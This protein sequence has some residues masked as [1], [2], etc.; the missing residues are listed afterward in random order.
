MEMVRLIARWAGYAGNRRL[1]VRRQVG[2]RSAK[3][4]V[5]RTSR[6]ARSMLFI[7]SAMHRTRGGRCRA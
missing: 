1:F 7:K 6:I 5:G 2:A 4:S 3:L